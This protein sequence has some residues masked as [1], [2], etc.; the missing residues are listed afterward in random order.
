MFPGM[1]KCATCIIPFYNENFY[2]VNTVVRAVKEIPEISQIVCVDDGSVNKTAHLLKNEHRDIDLV[3]LSRNKGKSYAVKAGV[4]K[5]RNE[6]VILVDA[7]LRGISSSEIREALLIMLQEEDID[8]NI[9]RRVN[10]SWLVKMIRA[11]LLLSGE[12]ILKKVDLENIFNA[13]VKG[14]QLEI[15]INRY[16]KENGKKVCWVPHSAKNTYKIMKKGFLPG[17]RKE[18]KMYFS[19]ITYIG[20]IAFFEQVFNYRFSRAESRVIAN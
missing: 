10:S 12:R 17:L 11:D 15:A 2:Q 18:I 19:I 16:M 8:M 5:S 13:S 1:E 20:C 6:I 4:E 3:Q 14:Y 9:L 7:D